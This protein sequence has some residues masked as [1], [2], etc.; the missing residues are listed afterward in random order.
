M[1]DGESVRSFFYFFFFFRLFQFLRFF[2][3]DIAEFSREYISSDYMVDAIRIPKY[4]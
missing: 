3:H 2:H 4:P 1:F